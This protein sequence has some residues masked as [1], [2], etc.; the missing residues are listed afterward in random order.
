MIKKKHEK[1]YLILSAIL[2]ITILISATTNISADCAPTIYPKGKA[3][4]SMAYDSANDVVIV[5]G[6]QIGTGTTDKK[7]DTM[8]YDYN[9]NNWTNLNPSEKPY[10]STW[11]AMAYDSESEKI[12]QFGGVPRNGE[13][14]NQ[15]WAYDYT[16]NTW[17]ERD[18]NETPG[19][20][21][22]HVMA[23]DSESD[24]V[25]M[26]GGYLA[27]GW[28][29]E[30]IYIHYNDTWAYNYNT[31][32]WTNM[33]PTGL[34]IGLAE[35]QITYDS[36]SDRV[37]MFGGFFI[38]PYGDYN[39][40]YYSEETW[41]Y[42]Y[43]TN[44]WENITTTIH[45]GHR[46][47]HEMAYDSESDRVILVGGWIMQG[48]TDL[49][50]ETWAFDY[51]TKTW[52]EMDPSI[53]EGRLAHKIAYDS[54]SD[55]V[56]LFGGIN[57]TNINIIYNDVYIYDYNNNN[58]TLMSKEICPTPSPTPTSLLFIPIISVLLTIAF[59]QYLRRRK[60]KI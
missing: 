60:F 28:N 8:A 5:Y 54:E 10:P 33:T 27:K 30:G 38:S 19:M 16:E 1:K 24:V 48:Y 22:A 32:T 55:L 57:T 7:Y 26:H 17:T 14:S 49:Q 45:P 40:D 9:N 34:D 50:Y 42:D 21:G 4:H 23:Y 41:A 31:N 52:E 2:T 58:W 15:T 56:I 51:N 53:T 43:N 29:D 3:G 20:R 47:D 36:E 13:A 18:P 35:A 59:A 25:I 37:I 11:G 39:P 46:V 12:I 6:G 44:T